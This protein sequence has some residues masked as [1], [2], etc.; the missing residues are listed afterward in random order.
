MVVEGSEERDAWPTVAYELA[1]DGPSFS[2]RDG[3]LLFNRGVKRGTTILVTGDRPRFALMRTLPDDRLDPDLIKLGD[4]RV[5]IGGE[6]G[7][8]AVWLDECRRVETVFHPYGTEYRLSSPLVPGLSIHLL[9]AQAGDWGL[10]ARLSLVNRSAQP[11]DAR[12]DVVYGGLARCGRTMDAAYIPPDGGDASRNTTISADDHATLT[13]RDLPGRVVVAS[14]PDGSSGPGMRPAVS[15]PYVSFSYHIGLTDGEARC[16]YL[17]AGQSGATDEIER[18]VMGADPEHLI[19]EGKEYYER[20]LRPFRISTPNR[21]LDAG[22]LTAILNLE[23]D[24]AAPA[25]LEGVHWWSA[26]WANNYQISAALSLGQ[27]ERARGA[28]AFFASGEEGPCPIR[29]ASGTPITDPAYG[30]ADSRDYGTEDG[31]PY[32][33]L[34]LLR[35]HEHTGDRTLLDEVWDGLRRALD[36]LWEVRDRDGDLLLDWHLH[37]NAFLYQADHLGM[38]G[39]AASPS[40]M[41]MGLLK[42]LA[43]VADQLGYAEDRASWALRAERMD[44]RLRER[45][46]NREEGVFYNHVDLQGLAHL[47]HY[48]TDLVFPTLYTGLPED[49]GWQSLDHLRRTLCLRGPLGDDLLMRVG[50]FKPSIFG[51]DNVMPTQMAEA[52]RAFFMQGDTDTGAALLEAVALA[53]TVFTDAPGNFPERMGDDGKG[54]ANYIFGNPIG[55][56]IGGVV[57]GLFGLSLADEGTTLHWQPGFPAGWDHAAL[58]L[59]YAT[60]SFERLAVDM[61]TTRLVYAVDNAQPR[62]VDFSV[63]LEPGR[64]TRVRVGDADIP[65]SITPALGA[66]RL[67]A[68]LERASACRVTI[69]YVP[70][71]IEVAGPSRCG[72]GMPLHWTLSSAVAGVRDPRG[73]LRDIEV[74]GGAIRAVAAG[75]VGMRQFF[76]EL[77][78]IPVIYPIS[79][80]IRPRYRV[81]WDEALYDAAT[82]SIHL[83]VRVEAAGDIPAGA[84]MRVALASVETVIDLDG[85]GR[86]EMMRD[87]VWPGVALLPV[88]AYMVDCAILVGDDEIHRE[89]GTVTVRGR[90]EGTRLAMRRRR[91]TLARNIDL[92]A[93]YN[94]STVRATSRWRDEDSEIDLTALTGP[95]GVLETDAGPFGLPIGDGPSLV[96]VAYGHSDAY[97]RETI[98]GDKPSAV[99]VPVGQW[100]SMLSLLYLTEVESRHTGATVGAIRLRYDDGAD[101]R[102]PLVVGENVDTLYDHFARATTPIKLRAVGL[103]GDFDYMNLITLP[104]DGARILHSFIVEVAVPDVQFGLIAATVIASPAPS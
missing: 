27:T 74:D 17:V 66:Q 54:V 81:S 29:L 60:V 26:Y 21:V 103:P 68:N 1:G 89:T 31:L 90:D 40:L 65:Y 41:M 10:V 44:E 83:H 94:A 7:H 75:D 62:Q 2:T 51:N 95:S 93:F 96:L 49:Y 100:A 64:V 46:W 32:Y 6:N 87:I 88:G 36:R 76:V 22:F 91:D 92:R 28:L 80:D 53:S 82:R 25:W 71:D 78:D 33:I 52:A 42:K 77:A 8:G 56:F 55:S 86:G 79:L 97:T 12:V 37:C 39:A 84:G 48:Y 5:R 102:V 85:L 57:A 20:L 23:Y 11:M 69:D 99:E 43:I 98:R 19:A 14:G 70:R 30:G 13:D 104:C 16:V 9:V 45:L 67:A 15:G 47:A 63:Y 61:S 24:Y 38:P 3:R 101:A 50:D 58:T 72:P 34:Q 18:A 59:P 4:G 73:A 35:Y